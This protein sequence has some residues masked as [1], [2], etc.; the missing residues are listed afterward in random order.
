MHNYILNYKHQ[1]E[2]FCHKNEFTPWVSELLN[3]I[4]EKKKKKKKIALLVENWFTLSFLNIQDSENS[5]Y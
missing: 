3:Q 2:I 1:H 5:K 4:T